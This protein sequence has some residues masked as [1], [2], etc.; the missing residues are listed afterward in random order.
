MKTARRLSQT[1]TDNGDAENSLKTTDEQPEHTCTDN[2]PDAGGKAADNT[3]GLDRV[4]EYNSDDADIEHSSNSHIEPMLNAGKTSDIGNEISTDS[5]SATVR[6][7]ENCATLGSGL[8]S[9]RSDTSCKSKTSTNAAD[10]TEISKL[11][12]QGT[13]EHSHDSYNTK[14][15]DEGDS[16]S[17]KDDSRRMSPHGRKHRHSRSGSRPR[18]GNSRLSAE[19]ENNDSSSHDRHDHQTKS[20]NKCRERAKRRR[21]RKR[22]RSRSNDRRT[23]KSSKY[24]VDK[25]H[26]TKSE[27]E[28]HE[29]NRRHRRRRSRS[30]S[31]GRNSSSASSDSDRNSSSRRNRKR[32]N[33]GQGQLS[34]Q[35][36]LKAERKRLEKVRKK[37]ERALKKLRQLE[38]NYKETNSHREKPAE[39]SITTTMI[40]VSRDKDIFDENGGKCD[41]NITGIEWDQPACDKSR[42][43]FDVD[44]II[45]YMSPVSSPSVESETDPNCCNDPTLCLEETPTQCDENELQAELT[46]S[47]ECSAVT[48]DTHGRATDVTISECV[49]DHS[50]SVSTADGRSNERLSDT[51][52]TDN[53]TVAKTIKMITDDASQTVTALRDSQADAIDSNSLKIPVYVRT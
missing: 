29:R 35:C 48:R 49:I 2:S 24:G 40:S 17:T 11:E 30:Y 23:R 6:P 46:D 8:M 7:S 43:A 38:S 52:F 44:F 18:S 13:S 36:R 20:T 14:K 33:S 27:H 19:I 26:R 15:P 34:D 45:S 21:S 10:N 1:A 28:R 5:W 42:N 31:R 47:A 16:E 22:S 41:R 53:S 32:G 12:R 3:F 39:T 37:T 25:K 4:K 51:E 9:P 50:I